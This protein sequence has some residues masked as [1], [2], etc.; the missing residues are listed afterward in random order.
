[1]PPPQFAEQALQLDQLLT[2]QSIR[3][4]V[5]DKGANVLIDFSVKSCVFDVTLLCDINI[6]T[7][8]TIIIIFK[9]LLTL[10]YYNK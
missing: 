4:S 8:I 10:L 2:A 7:I 9:K 5:V 3:I 6:I 1:V